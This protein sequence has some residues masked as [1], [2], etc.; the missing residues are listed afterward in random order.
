MVVLALSLASPNTGRAGDLSF[1]GVNDYLYQ[2]V[3]LPETEATVEF[4]IRPNNPDCGLFEARGGSGY[5]RDLYLVGGNLYARLYSEETIHTTGLNLANGQWHH[6][7]HVFGSSVGGQYLYVDGVLQASGSKTQSDFVA[8]DHC[9][10]G[11][12]RR[13]AV[14]QFMR[15]IDEIR[16]WS[17]ARSESE[18]AGNRFVPLNGNEPNLEVYL[19]F[20]EGFGAKTAD[21]SGHGWMAELRN[22]PT[23]SPTDEALGLP[24][25][26]P[27]PASSVV[28]NTALLQAMINTNGLS[29]INSFQWGA[30]STA[31]EFDGFNDIA[32]VSHDPAFN[33]FPLT[34]SAW[35]KAEHGT[36]GT[37]VDNYLGGSW[38]GWQ[39]WLSAGNVYALYIRTT[40]AYVADADYALDGGPI[41]DGQWHHIAFTVDE[42]GG[43]LYVD[44]VVRA[45]GSWRGT[46]GPPTRSHG[47]RFGMD[48]KAYPFRG[49]LDEVTIWS[50]ALDGTAVADLMTIPPG[51]THLQHDQLLGYWDFEDAQGIHVT[52]RS[53]NNRHAVLGGAPAW[54]PGARPL[55]TEQTPPKS[56]TVQNGVLDLDGFDDHLGVPDNIWF[57][58]DF[59]VE[60]WVYPRAY[61]SWS[62]IIDFGR[63]PNADNVLLA[64]SAGTTGQVRL[65]IRRGSASQGLSAPVL[66]PLRQWT[67]IAASLQAG[68]AEIYFNGVS[69]VSGPVHTPL[70]VNRTENFIGRS[71]WSVDAYAHALLEDVRIWSTALPTETLRGWM[72]RYVDPSH[73]TY[74]NLEGNWR[75]DELGGDSVVD[76]GPFARHA[77]LANGAQR[78]PLATLI[79]PLSDLVPGATYHFRGLAENTQGIV[80]GVSKSF[81]TLGTAAGGGLHF[82]G[83]DDFVRIGGISNSLPTEEVTV[84][85]WQRSRSLKNQSTFSLEPDPGPGNTRF[86]AHVPW[87]NGVVYWDFGNIS[88]GGRLTYT[89]PESIVGE[90]HHFAF[91]SSKQGNYM[92]IYHNGKVVNGKNGASALLPANYALLLGGVKVND[93]SYYFHGDLDEFRIWNVARTEAEIGLQYNT[94][95]SGTESGLVACYRFDEGSGTVTLDATGDG[96]SGLLINGVARFVSDAPLAL[97]IPS[98]APATDVQFGSAQLNGTV[99]GDGELPATVWFEYGLARDTIPDRSQNL[100]YYHSLGYPLGSLGAVNFNALP[101][102]VSGFSHL[103]IIG[104][105]EPFWPG[106]PGDYFAARHTGRIFLPEPGLYTLS[107]SSDDGS[108]LFLDGALIVNN[109]GTHSPNYV[110]SVVPLEAGYHHFE[111]RMFENSGGATLRAFYSGPGI[112][113]QIIPAEAFLDRQLFDLKTDAVELPAGMWLRPVHDSLDNLVS[114]QSYFYRLVAA[115]E[116][117]TNY[118]ETLS[119]V[120]PHPAAQ[121][122]LQFDGVDDHVKLQPFS[123][124][125]STNITVEFWMR[126]TDPT[127]EGTP[128]SYAA[129]NHYNEFLIYNYNAIRMH[130]ATEYIDT[131]ISLADG[132]WHHLAVTWSSADGALNI[133][134]NGTLAFATTDFVTGHKLVD[135]GALILG[136]EQDSVGGRFQVHQ[137]FAGEMDEV[138]VWN[139]IRTE[140]EIADD[141]DRTL[142]GS[143]EGLLLYY[144]FDEGFGSEALDSSHH[145]RTGSLVRGPY[146]G[147]L[148]RPSTAPLFQPLVQTLSPT[149]VLATKAT[150]RGVLNP[151][152]ARVTYRFDYGPTLAYGSTKAPGGPTLEGISPQSV[153]VEITDLVPGTTYHYRL[154]AETETGKQVFGLDESFTTLVLAAG[155]PVST[156]LTGGQSSSPVHAVDGLGNTI[157]AGLFSGSATFAQT[158]TPEPEG[159]YPTNAFVGQLARGADWVWAVNIPSTGLT[160]IHAVALDSQEDIVVAGDFEGT[161][162]FGGRNLTA[163]S[164]GDLFV[165]KLHVDTQTNVPEWI[166]AT[167]LGGT[168][169]HGALDVEIDAYDDIGV[170]GY[171][172]GT[173][174]V[175]G[176]PLTAGG[177]TDIF[178][179]KLDSDGQWLWVQKA[180]GAAVSEVARTLVVDSRNDLIVAGEFGDEGIPAAFVFEDGTRVLST[181]GGTDLFVAKLSSAG[182]W[183]LSR[184][185]GGTG[186]DWAAALDIDAADHSYLLGSFAGTADYDGVLENLNVGTRTN[187]FVAKLSPEASILWYAQGGE[188]TT[189]SLAVDE[190]GLIYVAGHFRLTTAFGLAD[191]IYLASHGNSDVFVSQLDAASGAWNWAHTIGGT[192]SEHGGSIT[193]DPDGSVVVSGSFQNTVQL[194]YVLLASPNERDIFIA[195]VDANQLYEHNTYVIG[196]PIPVPAEAQDASRADGGAYGIPLIALYEKSHAGTDA[197][198]AFSWS[199]AEH[200]LYAVR[201]V[202]AVLKWPLTAESSNLTRVATVVARTVWPTQPQVHVA[203]T[204]VELE[205][206]LPDFQ[207]KFL[208]LSFTDIA[209]AM[210]DASARQFTASQPGWSVLHF[211]HDTNNIP[212]AEEDPSVF[213]VVRTKTWD[214]PDCLDDS[215][216]AFIGQ[217]LERLN[218]NDPT[219]KNGYVFFERSFYDG[220]GEDAAH[221]RTTRTGPIIPVNE[222]TAAPDDDLVV[223]WYGTNQ[224]TGIAWSDDPVRYVAQWPPAAEELVIASGLGSG[225]LSP[226]DYPNK[227]VYRQ[228]NPDLPGYNP[229]EE[230]AALYGDTLHALRNDLNAVIGVSQPFTLLKYRAPVSG[231]WAMKV[232]AVVESNETYPFVYPAEAGKDLYLVPPLNYL[233]LSGHTNTW[234]EGPGFKD[235]E[236]RLYARAAGVGESGTNIVVRYWYPRQPG[237]FYDLDL[238]GQQNAP[239]GAS[240]PWL[241]RRADGTVDTPIDITYLTHWPTDVKTLQIGE[242]LF[243]EKYGLPAV[244]NFASA[245]IVYDQ[246]NPT[247]TDVRSSLVRLFDP[248]S[249]RTVVLD[250]DFELPPEIST[251]NR[252]GRLIFVDLPYVIRSRLFYDPLNKWLSFG[253]LLNEDI[254]YGGPDNPLLLPNIMTPRERARVESLSSDTPFRDAIERLY[255]LTRNPNRLDLNEDGA[256][257]PTLLIGLN[258]GVVTNPVT[259]VVSTNLVH[260]QL[261]DLPKAMTAGIGTGSGYLT[262]VENDDERLPGLPVILHVMKVKDGPY[263]GD[264]KV[265]Y[266]DNVFDERLTIRHSADFAGEPHNFEFAWYYKAYDAGVDR[267]DLPKVGDTGDVL[268]LRGWIPFPGLTSGVNGANDVTLGDGNLSSLLTLS[269][270]LIICRYRGYDIG[271]AKNVWS[272]WAGVIGGGEAQLAEGWVKRVVFGLNPFEARTKDFHTSEAM[273][274]ASMIRQA[275]ARYEGPIAFNPSADNLNQIGL[276]QAY[277]TVLERGKA[278]SINAAPPINFGPANN[279]LMLAAGRI[280][281][282]YMLLGNEAFAD[283]A[284]PTIGFRT[285]NAGYG[286]LAPSIFTFQNQLDSLLEEELCL[287]RGRD[288]RSA[289]VK[290][291]PVYN[292][293]FWNF[294]KAQGEVAYA[295]AYN[296]TDQNQDGFITAEDGRTMYPQGHGDAWG[297]YLTAIKT[298]YT[299]LRDPDFDWQRR[300][301]AILLG[302]I[303]QEVD[304]LDERKFAR[305]AAAKAKTG[306]EIIDLTYRLAYVDDPAGQFQGYK[307]TRPD[308]AWG[309]SEWGHRTGQGAFFDWVM[310]N[311]L[312]PAADPNPANTGI[313]KIDRTTVLEIGEIPPAFETVQHQVDKADAGLNPLGLA[314]NVVPFDIDPT[315]VSAGQTHFE[316]I[317]D[318]AIASMENAVSVF[319]HA[320]SLSQSLRALQDSVNDFAQNAQDRERDI[321]NRMIEV[322]GYP[323]AGD[324]GPGGTYPSS[325]DGPDLYHYMYVDT[326]EL[327]GD[328]APPSQTFT[329]YFDPLNPALDDV[330]HFFPEDLPTLQDTG[331]STNILSA[332]FPYS[333]A[334]YGFVPPTSW[335]R[336][337]APGQIQLAMSELLQREAAL[338]RALSNYDNLIR[339]IEDQLNLIEA[340][341]G[342]EARRIELFNSATSTVKILDDVVTGAKITQLGAKLAA[343]SARLIAE[344]AADGLPK[345]VGFSNDVSSGGRAAIRGGAEAAAKVFELVEKAGAKTEEGATA[346]KAAAEENAAEELRVETVNYELKQMVKALEQLI[347]QEAPLRLEVFSLKQAVGQAAGEYLARVADGFR[348]VDERLA[349]RKAVAGETFPR[350]RCIRLRNPTVGRH[351][352][353]RTRFPHRHRPPA[354]PRSIRERNAHR[355][356]ARPGR[357]AGPAL[358]ELPGPQG[359]ARLQQSPNRDRSF[360]VA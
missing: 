72:G 60:A 212:D 117:G 188:A 22:G 230:H 49:Q 234:V 54:V 82:D 179:G 115:T 41:D 274:Y 326:A 226:L 100:A 256:P 147:L 57:D 96:N 46:A 295:Q 87:G 358:P 305:A 285:D 320:N 173:V 125:P 281:D 80:A 145:G 333:A 210:V 109:D 45:V 119:F 233:R 105:Y 272:D 95:V 284:D 283:A 225:G 203:G 33:A 174:T 157:V 123:G 170:A 136:Q 151:G 349:F 53:G 261:G 342:L 293:V 182:Q 25:V 181:A 38:N 6:I 338:K 112:T 15:E 321:K 288:D 204:P 336:R 39:I 298:Y 315:R 190:D 51:D 291:P 17:I 346:A 110:S 287:L 235:H 5:D 30:G 140:K 220:A 184:R 314:K 154:V 118:S 300:T 9:V 85:F 24:V 279:A 3:D 353:R 344:I 116:R 36:R 138:R 330:K 73:P 19:P 34:V 309:L 276:I 187:M 260:E 99:K 149:P 79:E 185:A 28:N 26:T 159:G 200:R 275:G 8:Q 303:P 135:G 2:V 165:A 249:E 183:V 97:P 132:E 286:T 27:L 304:Y 71:N 37:L 236:G 238:D 319:N 262:V 337:R 269:D 93:P 68:W 163:A 78:L 297:H 133:Y 43:Q 258:W 192:G 206:A 106:A 215:E 130:I 202:T 327:N 113:N 205:P 52:D 176:S 158:L 143:E 311:A 16:V 290:A 48:D 152:G 278:L 67:H 242:T 252:G 44:G 134:K 217:E 13:D 224:V 280:A 11:Y 282:F 77:V 221:R 343:G 198:N 102:W 66:I 345:V 247:E 90:W 355:R 146:T 266:P 271:N 32:T 91:V 229:N 347:R 86:Q 14:P 162:T 196:E 195:R 141:M 107:L 153:S 218:H 65:E 148:Y 108:Q 156:K 75:F 339:Q 197:M 166:W 120:M 74:E 240:L 213:Q 127:K 318:R 83:V 324:I 161:A 257:D 259:R 29:A 277:S 335:G 64:L 323:Y 356:S 81:H 62:R 302:G 63:G 193:V 253:G 55:L 350:R 180:G 129:S 111:T 164:N 168:G 144:R 267:R 263:R 270:N 237:F 228:N 94:R 167:Q 312:L 265:L 10:I 104:P 7:A 20:E 92:R 137:A 191:P 211:L 160:R 244:R 245:R 264:L 239:V 340:R 348:L 150:L 31:L 317:Y 128:L 322:F 131:G 47:V 273:T 56:V 289:T 231:R 69:V 246:A 172:S 50:T 178:V 359:T 296:I 301:E 299:L 76:S 186:D 189:T 199:P 59:S 18:L 124:F 294:T 171:F 254:D 126:A 325:Y 255:R 227:Q 241:D 248:L 58:G 332:T 139:L 23:W 354:Q 313:F 89:L 177:G 1:D 334:D 223:V 103:D 88:A 121:T 232:F 70:G 194:G 360:L 201:P 216:P 12:A 21:A 207:F 40:A 329:A 357:S 331:M 4:W 84:E 61:N 352:R 268:D 98:A 222:D 251:M 292:R 114:G 155:W 341:H 316:Q 175:T 142:R 208:N 101:D 243:N 328:T 169:P 209:D 306:A 35:A 219:G 214:D 42:T 308:R 351:R 250:T 122:A 307:D 310:A